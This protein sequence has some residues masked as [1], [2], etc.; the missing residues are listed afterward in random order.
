MHSPSVQLLREHGGQASTILQPLK[1]PDSRLGL[2]HSAENKSK[3]LEIRLS[4]GAEVLGDTPRK[5]STHMLRIPMLQV[6]ISLCIWCQTK[7]EPQVSGVRPSL[8][9]SAVVLISCSHS[10]ATKFQ[11][12]KWG[13]NLLSRACTATSRR[14]GSCHPRAVAA[15]T[16]PCWFKGVPVTSHSLL[17]RVPGGFGHSPS[18][19]AGLHCTGRAGSRV[20]I[21]EL[22][23]SSAQGPMPSI[24]ALLSLR[25]YKYKTHR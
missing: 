20:G 3:Y 19:R 8:A 23:F 2:E 5:A 10:T 4:T 25:L 15:T 14:T 22:G 18:D 1:P 24:R 7:A 21:Q 17:S 11:L 9:Y 16:M 12:R 13:G 6:Q